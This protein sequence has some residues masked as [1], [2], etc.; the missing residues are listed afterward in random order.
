VAIRRLGISLIVLLSEVFHSVL[1]L[2]FC[3]SLFFLFSLHSETAS[4]NEPSLF[5]FS[6]DAIHIVA[7]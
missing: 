2:W 1:A 3:L 4:L 5:F 7:V 6:F